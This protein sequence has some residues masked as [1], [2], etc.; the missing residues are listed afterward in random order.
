[1]E[2]WKQIGEKNSEK[3]REIFEKFMTFFFRAKRL[4]TGA[5]DLAAPPQGAAEGKNEEKFFRLF[6]ALFG[7]HLTHVLSCWPI[8]EMDKLFVL[9]QQILSKTLPRL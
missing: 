4:G 8:P 1:M 5:P 2:L 9:S 7:R 6:F 3:K